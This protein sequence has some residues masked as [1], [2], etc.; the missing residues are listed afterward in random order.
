MSTEND[1]HQLVFPENFDER[2]VEHTADTDTYEE[3]YHLT[4]RDYRR[5]FGRNKYSSYNSFRVT[6]SQRLKRQ[7]AEKACN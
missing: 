4:E 5:A 7:R 1:D 3:A 6:R 2:F